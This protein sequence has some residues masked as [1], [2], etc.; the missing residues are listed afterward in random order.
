MNFTRNT[1]MLEPNSRRTFAG[2]LVVSA[3][4]AIC[5][6]CS[7]RSPEPPSS[8]TLKVGFITV[9]PVSDWGYNQSHEVSRLELE[10]ALGSAVKTTVAEKIPESA[11]VER[12]MERMIADGDTD[13]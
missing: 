11:D 13:R 7:N 9:G 6:G 2:T 5:A 4:I 1:K 3:A 10:K 8:S 12:V